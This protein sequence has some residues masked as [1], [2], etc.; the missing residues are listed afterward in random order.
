MAVLNKGPIFNIMSTWLDC[1][2]AHSSPESSTSVSLISSLNFE[3]KMPFPYYCAFL[4]K[5]V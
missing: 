2:N 1:L 4:V 5:N 3:E